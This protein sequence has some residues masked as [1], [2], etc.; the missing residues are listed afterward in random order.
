[1]RKHLLILPLTV[2]MLSAC[3]QAAPEQ[4]EQTVAE[5]AAAIAQET[6]I[7]DT[8]IDV[9]YRLNHEWEDVSV[10]TD[11]GDFDYPRA[12]KGG[13]NAP[14]MSIYT[15]ADLGDTQASTDHA[16]KMI[17]LVERMVSENPDKF[18]IVRSPSELEAAFKAGKIALP[19]GM[20]NGS[21]VNGSMETL[22]HFY[23]RGIRYITLAH[24]KTNHLADSSYDEN[25]Q[26][27]GLSPFG[28][29]VVAKMNALGMMVDISHL[30][31]DSASAVLDVTTVPVIASHSSVRYFTPDWERNISDA[32]VKRVKENG[33]VIMINYGSA[34]LHQPPHE[35]GDARD[36]AW[37]VITDGGVE[38]TPEAKDA[39]ELTYR[40]EHPYP[41]AN[42]GQVAD[43]IDYIKNLV[44]IDYVGIGSDYDGVGDSLPTG[45]KDVSSFPTLIAELINR[46]YS[47]PE[48]KKVMSGN[49]M[50]VWTAVEAGANR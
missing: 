5:R 13:L 26:W 12:V 7:V 34:F 32:L 3:E 37:K 48:I 43:H 42:V 41:Y 39:F 46:G 10:A 17:D 24:S 50:R 30:S 16:N 38:D 35:F 29:E 23:Q 14:F 2:L 4:T 31:D 1:M 15:P 25:R 6:M 45:L 20:E 21:P 40:A 27:N 44:G 8:H 11:G 22:Q 36:A 47:D 18:T 9:P 28:I 19:L 33:G 49:L